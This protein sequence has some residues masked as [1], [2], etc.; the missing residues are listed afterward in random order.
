MSPASE[1]VSTW[2]SAAS[3]VTARSCSDLRAWSA[4]G[5]GSKG[6]RLVVAGA[7]DLE[8]SLRRLSDQL[9]ITGSVDVVGL[10]TDTDQLLD[11][12][13]ILLAP[14][15][16]EPFGLSVVEAMAHGVPVV[17]ADG[18]AHIETVG[19]DGRLF[20]AGDAGAAARSLVALSDDIDLRRRVGGQLRDRQR[21]SFSLAR[22]VETL[23]GLYRQVIAETAAG[24]R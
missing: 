12:S 8:G 4:S 21:R 11:R 2:R 1:P 14:A 7:G 24:R 5:L 22:H 13:A 6:W 3:R 19:E 10:V 20:A 17:A 23:E 15:S 16:A 9:Q 18:G